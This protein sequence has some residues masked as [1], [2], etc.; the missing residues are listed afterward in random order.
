MERK[1]IVIKY[2]RL[3][4][5]VLIIISIYMVKVAVWHWQEAKEAFSL[6]G[7]CICIIVCFEVRDRVGGVYKLGINV[8]L[9]A[10]FLFGVLCES[11]MI[12]GGIETS[13]KYI[14]ADYIV[15]LGAKLE[16][17]GIS[18]TLQERLDKTVS[19]TERLHVPIVVSGGNTK[20]NMC[21]ESTVMEKYLRS[22]GVENNILIESRALNTRENFKYT[23]EMIGTDK[24]IVIVTSKEHMFRSRML[25]ISEGF[26]D[27]SGVCAETDAEMYLYFN[28]REVAAILR[29]I[30]IEV[31]AI[32]LERIVS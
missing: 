21:H 24:R 13:P 30:L 18:K 7:I 29:E 12:L 20:L 1:K 3:L 32:F 4:E 2:W 27:I 11:C 25:A 8:G 26:R 23:A 22:A 10:I 15:V 9:C 28:L 31:K 17:C 19:L 16:G 14:E 5:W 6:G